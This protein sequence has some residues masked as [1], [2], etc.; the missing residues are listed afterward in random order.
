VRQK[1]VSE[2]EGKGR[3][4]AKRGD[5]AQAMGAEANS[6]GRLARPA[7]DSHRRAQGGRKEAEKHNT[8]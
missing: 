7:N 2:Q 5:A 6:L 4:A 1:P 8:G 3:T